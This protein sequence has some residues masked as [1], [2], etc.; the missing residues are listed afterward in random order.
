MRGSQGPRIFVLTS[1][2]EDSAPICCLAAESSISSD[3]SWQKSGSSRKREAA[4][5]LR[6]HS[7]KCTGAA[8]NLPWNTDEEPAAGERIDRHGQPHSSDKVPRGSITA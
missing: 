6:P 3:S 1:E 5:T 7:E 4:D 8:Y 2:Y